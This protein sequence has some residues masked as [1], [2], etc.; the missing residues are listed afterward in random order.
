MVK[1]VCPPQVEP[2]C[3]YSLESPLVVLTQPADLV[4]PDAPDFPLL[5]ASSL[6]SYPS[7]FSWLRLS[8]TLSLATLLQPRLQLLN[9]PR[10]VVLEATPTGTRSSPS[11]PHNLNS[12]STR[13]RISRHISGVTAT[14]RAAHKTSC[15][16]LQAPMRLAHILRCITIAGRPAFWAGRPC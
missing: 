16:L 11:V 3:V 13:K 9:E 14:S 2:A 12:S 5:K 7:S 15:S 1:D 4:L 10:N 6:A 8:N